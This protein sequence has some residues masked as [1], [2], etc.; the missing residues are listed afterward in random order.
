MLLHS[1]NLW[2][3]AFYALMVFMATVGL[4]DVFFGFEE[5]KCSMSYMFEYPEYQKIELPKK[6]AKRYPA[7][8]L[9]L[10][11][12]GSYAEEHKVLPLTGIPVLFLPGNA[13]SYKQ[14]RSIGSIALRKAE[15]IDFKYHFDFF[16][17][18]FNEELVA[19]YGGSLQKQTKFVHECIKT[20]LKLYK[21]QEFAPKSV[22]I[23]GHSMGG[24]VARAL[25]TLKN[26]KQDLINLLVTQATPHVAPVMPLDRFITD[27]YMTVNNYWILNARQINLTTLSVAGGFRDYQVRSGLT[28]LP[29]LSHHTSALSVVSSA[30]PKTWVS[31]DHLSIVWCKQLQLTTVRAFF[32]LIDADTKQITQNPK[33]K[34]SVLNHHFIRHPAKHFEENP[35]IISDLTGTSM[36]VPVKVSKWTYVAYNESDKIYFTFPLAN[37]RKIYTHVY[38]QST[39]LDTNSWIF[40]CINSTSMC[41]QGVDLSWKAELLPTIKSLTL[42]LQDY[43]SL[44]HLVVYVPSIHGSKFVVDCEFF[45]KET[46]SIQLPVTHLFSFG[47]SSRKVILNTSGLFYNIELLNFGQIY[48]AFKINVVSKCSG[49]KEEITSIYKLHIPWSYEDSLTIAQ[50][51]S[52]TDISVK[53]HIA[54]P[55]ND[56]HV[57]LLKMYTSSDCQY[58]VT[59]KTSF[60]QILGQVVRFHGGALPAYVISSILLAYGGQLYSLFSTGH[61][62]EYA[63]MLD[64]EAKPYKVD[65]F[66]IMVKFLLGPSELPKDIKIISPDLPILT[67]VLI[68]ISWTTCG[69]FAIL[70]T[71]LYYVFKIVHL[72]ASLTTFKNSQT[73]NPKHSRRSEKKSNHH[74]DSAV[75]HLRLSAS[76]AEDSLR[77]HSTLINLLT[78]I[79]LLSMP[80]LI[81]WLKNLRYYFKLNPDPCKPLAFILIPTMAVL[82]N[83][84]TTSIKSSKLLKT[85]SQFPLPLAVGVIAFGSS[86]LYR[87]PCFVFIPLLLHALCNFM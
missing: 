69:A 31:T 9:Y 83:T 11:G 47:L 36:W 20:I 70:L 25:L 21:G 18:N 7:Y 35:A 28:F 15:D 43:P 67:T 51:P 59:V 14:V 79:V 77:M 64:K 48:Q 80:S 71:Y 54:Q 52:S 41:R 16:S 45:K 84:Y 26:F 75:H 1:V 5:N 55:D 3:L 81:Y 30:V 13:G 34:L 78:W 46:R 56:S 44:S 49:A 57:A 63:A 53:L 86:H 33:K 61:C 24:L 76:D 66:V 40:G 4:W 38:C 85:T 62:L 68:L 65:P 2:N 73:V 74:K 10:Y 58:E 32:D 37:H 39:M 72:Q 19:L 42:R 29:K 12:E 82:G 27:F 50:V 87:V 8:E 22:A 60:S 17:V 6:L 23:I